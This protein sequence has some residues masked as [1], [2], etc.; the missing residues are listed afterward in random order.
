MSN[1][2]GT[3][4]RGLKVGDKVHKTFEMREAATEDLFK[5]EALASELGGGAHTPIVF[6]AALIAQQ[7][8]RIGDY[9]G[10]VTVK[11]IGTLKKRDFAQLRAAQE[12]LDKLGEVE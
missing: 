7:L 3:L 6:Q 5:A 4:K 10:P 8:V 9:D 11:M 2:K 1:L 12:E